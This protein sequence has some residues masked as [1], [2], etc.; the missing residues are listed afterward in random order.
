[1][2]PNPNAPVLSPRVRRRTQTIDAVVRQHDP[3]PP[4]DLN[5]RF[6]NG[7]TFTTPTGANPYPQIEE[8]D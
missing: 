1:M 7:R 6:S 3:K 5:Y 2:Q 4:R 8:E